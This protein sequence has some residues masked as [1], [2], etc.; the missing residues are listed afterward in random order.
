MIRAGAGE[1]V[2]APP[3]K[4]PVANARRSPSVKAGLTANRQVIKEKAIQPTPGTPRGRLIK[5]ELQMQPDF[6]ARQGATN[7]DNG[8]DL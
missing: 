1:V 5:T 6:G 3:F 4:K 2:F 8:R 7:E